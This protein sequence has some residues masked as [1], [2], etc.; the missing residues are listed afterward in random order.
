MLKSIQGPYPIKNDSDLLWCKLLA[1]ICNYFDTRVLADV[2][3]PHC[4]RLFFQNLAVD[5]GAL[6][7]FCSALSE[8]PKVY[9]EQIAQPLELCS[10]M[11]AESVHEF[12]DPVV[13][14]RKYSHIET[15][16]LIS[17]LGRVKE[18]ASTRKSVEDLI[19]LLK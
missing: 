13:R 15:E 2:K 12:L 5:L 18:P 8:N 1:H 10:L 17:V 11:E 7:T 6:K 14:S 3:Y 4:N 19:M 9:L 16:K